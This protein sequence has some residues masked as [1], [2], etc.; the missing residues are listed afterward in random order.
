MGLSDR[1]GWLR[2]P[3][4]QPYGDRSVEEQLLGLEHALIETTGKTVFDIGCAEGAISQSFARAGALDV[5]G[6]EYVEDHLVVARKLCKDDTNIKFV[7]ANLK[8]WARRHPNPRQFD[9]VLALGVIHKL[10]FPDVGAHF[11]AKSC[12]DLLCFRPPGGVTDGIVKSKN[13]PENH[14]DWNAVMDKHGFILERVCNS[15]RNERV[16]YWRKKK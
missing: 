9:I 2:I 1:H 3:G 7:R 10:W 12:S 15:S 6:L 13:R 4:I 16:E 8:D 14:C 5:L 11:A